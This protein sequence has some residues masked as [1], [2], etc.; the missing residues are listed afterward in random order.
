MQRLA[1]E[2]SQQTARQMQGVVTWLR[3]DDSDQIVLFDSLTRI[4]Q[5][6]PGTVDWILRKPQLASWIKSDPEPPFLWL[7]GAPG[8]GKSV[9]VAR[10]VSFLHAFKDSPVVIHHFC[11]DTNETSIQYDH[12]VKSLLLQAARGNGDLVAH[13]H[14]EFVSSQ[15]AAI[16]V[17]EK[18]LEMAVDLISGS[19]GHASTGVRILL[20][21]LDECPVH[22]QRR[23]LRLMKGL[24]SK[25]G[26]CKVLVSSRDI[27]P[28]P[29]R[30]KH[31]LLSLAEEKACLRD[32]ISGYARLRLSAMRDRLRELGISDDDVRVISTRIGEKADGIVLTL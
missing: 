27:L 5:R 15:Q 28:A 30:Q 26:N 3:L 16:P 12:I 19:C 20:D 21:G 1:V 24:A 31:S 32:A 11:S 9:M 23:L 29:K 17:L 6:Y 10:L 7:Q 2:Q 8:T 13:I 14:D 22:Q 18:L 25:G 4:G